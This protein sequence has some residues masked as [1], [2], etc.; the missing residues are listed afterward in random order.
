MPY[1]QY[2]GEGACYPYV[3]LMNLSSIFLVLDIG[4]FRMINIVKGPIGWLSGAAFILVAIFSRIMNFDLRRDENIY[5]VP[6]KLLDSFALY[7]DFF[8]NQVPLSAWFFHL[9][10]M[11]LATDHVLFAARLTIFLAWIVMA[12]AIVFLT[13][14]LTGSK[15]VTTFAFLAVMTNDI[16]LSTTGLAGT[17][18]FLPMPFLYI[19][20]GTFLLGVSAE[21]LKPSLFFLSGFA[22]GIAS[23]IKI[24]A[25]VVGPIVLLATLIMPR[26]IGWNYR[27]A[28]MTLPYVCG[29]IAGA[30]PA[31]I[32]FIKAPA[33]FFAHVISWHT[34]PHEQWWATQPAK[35]LEAAMTFYG[36]LALGFS[37]WTAGTNA[38]MLFVLVFLLIALARERHFLGLVRFMR[39]AKIILVLCVLAA[40][41]SIAMIMTPSFPQYFTQPIVM[42]PLLF[43]II[44][45][46]LEPTERRTAEGVLV[47]ASILLCLINFPRLTM[48]FSR[49]P[50]PERWEVNIAHAKGVEIANVLHKRGIEGKVATLTPIYALEGGLPVYQELATGPFAYR[51][52]DLT[53][54]ELMK[55]FRIT[56][57]SKVEKLL[58]Q[59]P[60][61]AFLLGFF[62]EI[63]VPLLRYATDHGYVRDTQFGI[64]DREG[65]GYLLIR[66]P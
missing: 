23:A 38:M 58:E 11:V 42:L 26:E 12:I 25:A 56:S 31:I 15:T 65:E 1:F 34:G 7:K 2:F 22:L 61:A 16:L 52:G 45:R 9:T 60:P 46:K 27:F 36:K 3:H 18:N 19:G 14:Q 5:A 28:K 41:L 50:F 62:P 59:D 37:V 57:P 39:D 17:N 55:Y 32:Y 53:S 29:A 40:T 8:Y 63:E 4:K 10:K 21:K 54:P 44:F 43:A 13:F 66:S 48:S 6:A 64:T 47:A 30:L 24:S 33:S 49:L 51:S 20:L 35:G